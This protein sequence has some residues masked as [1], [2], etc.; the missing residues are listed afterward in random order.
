[1]ATIKEE[2]QAYQP[3]Q[4]QNIADL[5]RVPTNLE[6]K[7]QIGKE[8]TPDEFKYKYVEVKG[9][10]YRVPGVVLGDIKAL[11]N[12]FPDLEYVQVL[13]QG[14]GKNTRYQV[15]PV[16]VDHTKKDDLHIVDTV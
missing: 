15:I 6:V 8:G 12:K 7:E 11:L 13:K 2:A 10:Q 5:D 14:A 3:Q 1:M 9:I 16:A 4:T